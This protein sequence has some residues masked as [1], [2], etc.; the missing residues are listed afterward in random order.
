MDLARFEAS[1]EAS[2]QRSCVK[3]AFFSRATKETG[4]ERRTAVTNTG[5]SAQ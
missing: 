3:L 1:H 4:Y 5:C 2:Q